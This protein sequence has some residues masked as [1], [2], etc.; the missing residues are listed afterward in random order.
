MCDYLFTKIHSQFWNSCSA[1][2]SSGSSFLLCFKTGKS[3]PRSSN[4]KHKMCS[5]EETDFG[6]DSAVGGCMTPSS[7]DSQIIHELLPDELCKKCSLDKVAVRIGLKDAQCTECFL[8]SVRHKFRA[9]LGASKCVPRG[10]SVLVVYDGG[11]ISTV[12]LDVVNNA[13]CDSTFKR[14]HLKPSVLF[15]DDC[16]YGDN[17]ALA[18]APSI[19]EQLKTCDFPKFYT[20]LDPDHSIDKLTEN[21]TPKS[22]DTTSSA[23]RTIFNQITDQTSR[24][25]FIQIARDNCIRKSAKRLQCDFAFV[26]DIGPDLATT[27]L[28]NIVLGRGGSVA[29]DV[30]LFDTRTDVQIVRPIRDLNHKEVEM[31]IKLSGITCTAA[32]NKVMGGSVQALTKSFVA[33][34]QSNFSSTVSTVFKTADKMDNEESDK[35]GV[36]CQF[37]HSKVA[38]E[39]SSTTLA[40]IDYSRY[41][42]INSERI[43]VRSPNISE[44]IQLACNRGS[45]AT[46]TLCHSCQTIFGSLTSNVLDEFLI[47]DD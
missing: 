3:T 30:S 35:G 23:I 36:Y 13:I 42:S 46:T 19:W 37:C 43:D 9:T 20:T 47:R 34:L 5:V 16:L 22:S 32:V 17:V 18:M 38:G 24:Q 8:K 27:F 15:I 11:P 25:E 14:I 12:L 21:F 40:A 7:V 29:Q 1:R 2:A 31:Y 26:P 41:V 4:A 28:T 6:D 39:K 44:S 45:D 33:G 10:A